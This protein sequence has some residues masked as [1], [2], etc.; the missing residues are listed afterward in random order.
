[1]C[2]DV[3]VATQGKV[4]TRVG[5]SDSTKRGVYLRLQKMVS[6]VTG[7]E[8]RFADDVI[9]ASDGCQYFNVACTKFDLQIG[10]L[11]LLAAKA[12]AQLLKNN[13]L[14]QETSILPTR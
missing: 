8:L 1:M 9:E 7:S 4:N 13:P 6:Q 2:F 11:D 10:Y 3:D 14:S 12:H 5:D